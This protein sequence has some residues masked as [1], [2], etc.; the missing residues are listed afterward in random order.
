MVDATSSVRAEDKKDYVTI[1][2]TDPTPAI[3]KPG[4]SISLKV[5]YRLESAEKGEIMIW[6]DVDG[7]GERIV[8]FGW[9]GCSKGE[10]NLDIPLRLDFPQ[11]ASRF[12]V[13]LKKPKVSDFL[14]N[15]WQ[16]VNVE[17]TDPF[18]DIA[19]NPAF[20]GVRVSLNKQSPNYQKIHSALVKMGVKTITFF[21]R[22]M[23]IW[24]VEFGEDISVE[25]AQIVLKACIEGS[26]KVPDV[27]IDHLGL[28]GG[29]NIRIAPLM[30]S[31]Y[32]PMP[33]NLVQRLVRPGLSK[34]EFHGIIADWASTQ[35]KK[36]A[37]KAKADALKRMQTASLPDI[38][39][40]GLIAYYPLNGSLE[41]ATRVTGQ[42]KLDGGRL[43]EDAAFLE[44]NPEVSR[45]HRPPRAGASVRVE[46]FNYE[47]FTI[48]L[49]FCPFTFDLP[50]G[51]TRLHPPGDERNIL[52]GGLFPQWFAV[53]R[54]PEGD[55][56]VLANGGKWSHVFSGHKV[57]TGTWHS[58]ACALDVATKSVLMCYDGHLLPPADL[59]SEFRME[60]DSYSEMSSPDQI[61][62]C[63]YGAGIT[64]RGYA[65]NFIMY[66]RALSGDELLKLYQTQSR[67]L[68]EIA[69]VLLDGTT[70]RGYPADSSYELRTSYGKLGFRVRQVKH[71]TF[72]DGGNK[73]SVELHNGDVA[74]G[75]MESKSITVTDSRGKKISVATD[76]V[77]TLTLCGPE[78]PEQSRSSEEDPAVDSLME[79]LGE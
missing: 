61:L 59:S 13:R 23:P 28:E 78:L 27:S 33:S 5:H 63:H 40:E 49:D 4:E 41:D 48:S 77:R 65:D 68:D 57:T 74:V 75:E 14:Q 29:K 76:R 34:A 1:V 20:D 67:C 54:S 58:V 8:V 56:R 6:P 35:G 3:V 60:A 9:R 72:S 44:Q 55:L 24:G 62:I 17:W 19:P 16:Y 52:A 64:F 38:P 50:P 73:V 36:R 10:G 2:G 12:L 42:L 46:H 79:N 45:T 11:K 47:A 25:A 51:G 69:L 66:D 39:T 15:E 71:I 18:P 32:L 21:D 26:G 30:A 31:K 70:L 53:G 37:E 22:R 43:A 7:K